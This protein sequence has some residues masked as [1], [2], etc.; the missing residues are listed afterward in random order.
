MMI[1]MIIYDMYS[2]LVNKSINH[3]FYLPHQE[4]TVEHFSALHF[5]F[6]FWS[7]SNNYNTQN[8]LNQGVEQKVK[9]LNYTLQMSR[10]SQSQN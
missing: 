8:V 4:K 3:I 2:D 5:L 1:M 7:T 10:F 9:G 6:F